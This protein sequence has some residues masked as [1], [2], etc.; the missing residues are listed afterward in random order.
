M[1]RFYYIIIVCD[2]LYYVNDMRLRIRF[3][4]RS[5]SCVIVAYAHMCVDHNTCLRKHRYLLVLN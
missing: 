3:E 5:I 4:Q 1:K 2:I